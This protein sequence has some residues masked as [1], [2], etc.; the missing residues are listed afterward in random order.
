[1]S[2]YVADGYMTLG[3]LVGPA[4]WERDSVVTAEL[5]LTADVTQTLVLESPVFPEDA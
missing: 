3:Y 4:S 2:V 5:S 1:M